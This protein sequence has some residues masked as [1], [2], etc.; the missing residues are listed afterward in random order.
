MVGRLAVQKVMN[1][2]KKIENG[3]LK[4]GYLLGCGVSTIKKGVGEEVD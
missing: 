2:I 4:I 3:I 1:S